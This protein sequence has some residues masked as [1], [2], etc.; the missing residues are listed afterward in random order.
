[1]I[2]AIDGTAA[3]GKS[4]L[5]RRIAAHYGLPH[6]D[7]GSIY[8]GVA[9]DVIKGGHA[10]TDVQAAAEAARNLDASTLSD[11]ELRLKGNG[12]AASV[13]AAYPEVRAEL[14]AFQRAFAANPEGAVVEGRDIGTV[15]C[16]GAHAK[17]F[18]TASAQS[19]A[20]R[21]YI[22]LKGYG[23][24]TT[25]DAVLREIEDRDR[26]DRE[27]PVSPLIPAKDALL[28]DTTE[29]DIEKALA[30]ALELIDKA[31]GVR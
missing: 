16:P 12:E 20:K 21:R 14:L 5:A 13:V 18:V 22:E 17:I 29:L 11:P 9:R 15:V 27:R 1:M 24:E 7:T 26:R 6:L 4:T 30:T 10:L 28:L 25:E 19:R 8:R 2:I 23:V 31:A 3:A